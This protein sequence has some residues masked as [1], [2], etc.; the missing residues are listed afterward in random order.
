MRSIF[1]VGD[2]DAHRYALPFL[3]AG[4]DALVEFQIIAHHTYV[5]QRFRA[6]ADQR[7]TADRA[8]DLAILDEI[9][10]G[11]R[12]NEVAAGDINPVRR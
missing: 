7:C 5:L 11:R 8:R 4:P 1:T 9:A 2:A 6:V 10:F 3:A 12:E